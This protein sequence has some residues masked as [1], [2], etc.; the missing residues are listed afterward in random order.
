MTTAGVSAARPARMTTPQVVLTVEEAA[1]ALGI[2]RT[3]MYSLISSGA[4]ESVTIATERLLIYPTLAV[5]S[6]CAERPPPGN[7]KAPS[8]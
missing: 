7:A 5:G 2:G 3:L 4:V 1:Q 8:G 6:R